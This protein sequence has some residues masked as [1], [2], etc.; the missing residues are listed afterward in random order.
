MYVDRKFLQDNFIGGAN[1][2]FDYKDYLA[3]AYSFPEWDIKEWEYN[4]EVSPKFWEDKNNQREFVLWV[5][6]K[7]GIDVN[8]KTSLRR[9]NALII[10]KYGGYKA[11]RVAG[12]LFNLIDTISPGKF[13]EWEIFKVSA[14]NKDKAIVATRWLIEEKLN[15]TFEQACKLKTKDFRDNGLDGML[16]KVCNHS[17]FYALNLAYPS[18]FIRTGSREK[19]KL[20]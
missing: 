12:G 10:S 14:W 4:K 13:K 15:I 6:Q 17:I 7:E 3:I 5:A 19:I 1:K 8:N 16:Q 9:I 20:K 18:I 11:M 2:F